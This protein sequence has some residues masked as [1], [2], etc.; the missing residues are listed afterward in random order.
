MSAQHFLNKDNVNMLWDVISDEEI[1][2][3]LSREFQS[4]VSQ[5]FIYNIVGFYE[6]ES[7]KTPNLIEINKNCI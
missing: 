4:E 3:S 5:I 2:R 7:K 1:F 6:V